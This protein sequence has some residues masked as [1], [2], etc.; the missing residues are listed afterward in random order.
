MCRPELAGWRGLNNPDVAR[1]FNFTLITYTEARE[2]PAVALYTR[3]LIFAT[4]NR[5]LWLHRPLPPF[6]RILC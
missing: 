3:R 6:G 1:T 2:C 5:Q 4:G